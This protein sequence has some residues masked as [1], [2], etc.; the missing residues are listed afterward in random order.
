MH[1]TDNTLSLTFVWG[2]R[3]VTA[4]LAGRISADLCFTALSS[5]CARKI[6]LLAVPEIAAD[7]EISCVGIEVFILVATGR[8]GFLMAPHV[9]RAW[10]ETEKRWKAPR[11]G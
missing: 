5:A 2:S 7:E 9:Y 11:D 3:T 10:K 4:R 1:A 6:A 8:N